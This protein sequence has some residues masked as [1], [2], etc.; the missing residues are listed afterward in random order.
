MLR[1]GITIFLLATL[2]RANEQRFQ[3]EEAILDTT[4]G[5]HAADVNAHRFQREEAI[6]DA[7]HFVDGH[8]IFEEDWATETQNI[9]NIPG[10]AT[11]SRQWNNR[12]GN[13]GLYRSN[14]LPIDLNRH[15]RGTSGSHAQTENRHLEQQTGDHAQTQVGIDSQTQT[16]NHAQTQTDSH[17]Q[18][19]TESHNKNQTEN[20]AQT[21]NTHAMNANPDEPGRC[22]VFESNGQTT[23]RK[24]KPNH[25][26]T[27]WQYCWPDG[28]EHEALANYRQFTEGHT[29]GPS[30]KRSI[31]HELPADDGCYYV[32]NN[33]EDCTPRMYYCGKEHQCNTE[34]E[35]LKI[36]DE[37]K[38]PE[39]NHLS[40]KKNVF[41]P[42]TTAHTQTGNHAEQPH[43]QPGHGTS[44]QTETHTEQPHQQP[45]HNT[46]TQTEH[47]TEI[48]E[49]PCEEPAT[50]THPQ[51]E[52]HVEQPRQ[53]P[54]H[55]TSTQTGTHTEQ[56]PHQKP[57]HSVTT[58]TENKTETKEEPCDEPK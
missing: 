39:Y 44:T 41:D 18:N 22:G 50:T 15:Q 9:A 51:T 35:C 3:R 33:K 2:A 23:T 52:N 7:D 20:H 49:E 54:G 32:V 12:Q 38:C 19:Q 26:C 29:S 57:G 5:A 11:Y 58:Q 48:K 8:N 34:E 43:Q 16:D 6:Y 46:T 45:G 55:G 47:K 28:S 14:V 56:Q 30:H 53:Q 40:F 1:T 13:Q 31:T 27:T 42:A 17:A 10:H 25:Y 24:C 21:Q 37:K 36:I 4:P